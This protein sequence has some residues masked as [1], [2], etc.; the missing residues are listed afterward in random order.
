MGHLVSHVVEVFHRQEV[1]VEKSVDAVGKAALLTPVKLVVLDAAG[2]ALGPADLGK[3]V[4]FCSG[5][6]LATA[7]KIYV[8][9]RQREGGASFGI[10]W[11]LVDVRA[12][13]WE[14]CCSFARN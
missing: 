1:H 3:A 9:T 5:T 11:G 4:G 7:E 12:W 2:N 10:G 13:I 14:R 8:R 6:S